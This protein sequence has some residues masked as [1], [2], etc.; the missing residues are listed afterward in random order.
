VFDVVHDHGGS[1]ALFAAKTK[2]MLYSAAGIPMAP[3]P[4]RT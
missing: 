1:T 2:F 3:G 4:I